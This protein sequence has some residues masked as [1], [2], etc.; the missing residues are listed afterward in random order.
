MTLLISIC[1]RKN[2]DKNLPKISL[3]TELRSFKN[4]LSAIGYLAAPNSTLVFSPELK[5]D[6]EYIKGTIGF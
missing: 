2:A 4:K 1:E 6:Y 3:S 5:D